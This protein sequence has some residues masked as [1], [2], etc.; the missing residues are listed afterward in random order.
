MDAQPGVDVAGT[1]LIAILSSYAGTPAEDLSAAR[2]IL[3]S[4]VI[5]P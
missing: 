3:D 4:L 1:R 2:A 5:T